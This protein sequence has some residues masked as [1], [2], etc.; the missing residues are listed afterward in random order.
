MNSSQFLAATEAAVR[1]AEEQGFEADIDV[2]GADTEDNPDRVFVTMIASHPEESVHHPAPD[3]MRMPV[4]FRVRVVID[5][6][7]GTIPSVE[8]VPFPEQRASPQQVDLFAPAPLVDFDPTQIA[9]RLAHDDGRLVQLESPEGG[10]VC[11]LLYV[12]SRRHVRVPPERVDLALAMQ[13]IEVESEGGS[14]D[15]RYRQIVYAAT[16]DA[17]RFGKE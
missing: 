14:R 13:L 6:V 16:P 10:T 11:H 12:T 3:G 4:E 2:L 5:M 17:L 7:S 1:W 8:R 9:W 15:G